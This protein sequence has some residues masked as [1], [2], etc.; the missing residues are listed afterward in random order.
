MKNLSFILM[1][2]SIIFVINNASAQRDI[3]YKKDST[4]IRCKIVKEEADKYDYAFTD[5]TLKVFKTKILKTFV[6]SVHYNFYDTNLVQNKIFGKIKKLKP[7][8]AEA[9]TEVK[10]NWKFSF[11]LGLNVGNILEFNSNPGPD[12][13]SFTANS[14]LDFGL[15]YAKE[16]RKFEM[17][18][19]LHCILGF[20]KTGITGADH[21]QR[22]SDNITSLH[23]FSSKIGKSKKWDFNLIARSSTTIFN[24]Y[25]GEYLKDINHLGK[26][27]GFLSPYDVTISPGIKYEPDKY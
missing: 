21:I 6:D 9:V 19:E 5:S 3:I 26:I 24:V 25:D 27:Q 18:N 7:A 17:T 11:G 15:N 16:G 12:K 8:P 2:L 20:Q 23:D 14:S 1:L 13:K 4:Q 22:V 10:K